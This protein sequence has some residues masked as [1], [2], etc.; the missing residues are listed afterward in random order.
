MQ[1]YSEDN[2]AAFEGFLARTTEIMECLTVTGEYDY[3]LGIRTCRV[4]SFEALMLKQIFGHKAV[5]SATSQIALREV[6]YS[7]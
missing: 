2:R 3:T 4:K 6:K 1:D 5:A 7:M